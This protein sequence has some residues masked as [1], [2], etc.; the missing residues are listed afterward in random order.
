M[1]Q[2]RGILSHRAT[3]EPMCS[4]AASL[5]AA[6][7]RHAASMELVRSSGSATWCCARTFKS[8]SVFSFKLMF[9]LHW[10]TTLHAILYD[11][12]LGSFTALLGFS[13]AGL[14]LL[15]LPAERG[16]LL[17]SCAPVT[18][19]SPPPELEW[20]AGFARPSPGAR[21]TGRDALVKLKRGSQ[22]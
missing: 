9:R 5:A 20:I 21:Q 22:T 12:M 1:R 7:W 10:N 2:L 19:A 6:S 4:Q 3:Q 16:R 18:A 11:S 15:E 13:T 14:P 17:Q 8:P